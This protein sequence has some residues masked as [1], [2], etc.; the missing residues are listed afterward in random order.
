ML[1]ARGMPAMSFLGASSVMRDALLAT[2]PMLVARGVLPTA[3]LARVATGF[4]LMLTAA[5][6]VAS[7]IVLGPCR[8]RPGREQA[9]E[10]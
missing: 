7:V 3:M 8:R 6:L 2:T 4:S 1:V 10:C 5:A 9:P